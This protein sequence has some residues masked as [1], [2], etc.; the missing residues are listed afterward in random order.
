MKILLVI[1]FVITEVSVLAQTGSEIFLFDLKE[2]KG[3]LILSNPK[4][5]TD[6]I[7][8]DN[9]P[10]FDAEKPIIYYSSFNED[11][12]SDIKIY[13]YKT[14]ERK[15]LTQTTDR[16]YSPTLTPDQ[17]FVSCIIQ[18]DNGGQ[19]LGKYPVD[20][21]QPTVLIDNLIV[22]YHR[23]VDADRVLLFV[24]GEP[25]T[26]HVYNAKTKE[27]RTVDDKIG[28][29]LHAIP[30]RKS[31]SYVKKTSATDWS[32][33]ELDMATLNAKKLI[34][35]LPGRED[36]CWTL[37]GRII[38]SDGSKIYS[39]DPAKETV[40]SEMT[41]LSGAEKLKGVTRLAI[42][43]KSDKLAVVVSE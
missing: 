37:N 17:K 29:S 3:K 30:T 5:I 10:S 31:M 32:I 28:R 40:W 27:D 25:Q 33:M 36:L 23:W 20:G 2:K 7:G 9:Q 21:G 26:L 16:E 6:H 4:N 8:Y 1:V 39:N 42:N 12:R 38:M 19:D 35:T 13:N 41:V 14:G 43:S 18:R 34:G 24:L 22:G 11:G 15:S